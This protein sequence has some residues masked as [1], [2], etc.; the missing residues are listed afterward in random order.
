MLVR[1]VINKFRGQ[2]RLD[3]TDDGSP[4]R[5][6]RDNPEMAEPEHHIRNDQG[7][8][9]M[10]QF[11]LITDGGNVDMPQNGQR[12]H[13]HNGHQGTWNDSVHARPNNHN[14]KAYGNQHVNHPWH[15]NDV[16]EL[17]EKNEDSQGIHE[18]VHHASRNKAH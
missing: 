17:S 1:D 8:H 10:G 5:V 4:Q 12:C 7:R 11:S 13:H 16:L 15:M 2:Q 3:E 6:R 14:G 9:P 18:P